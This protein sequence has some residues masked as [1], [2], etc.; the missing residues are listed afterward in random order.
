[1]IGIIL[2]LIAS[3]FFTASEMAFISCDWI[4]LRHWA[5]KNKKGAKFALNLLRNQDKLLITILVGNN[6]A[7]VGLSVI[8]SSVWGLQEG[9][10]ILL[11]ALLIFIFGEVLPKSIASRFKE[12]L[13]IILAKPYVVI[14]WLFYPLIFIVYHSSIGI[15]KLFNAHPKFTFHK[16]TR[17][18][19]RVASKKALSLPEHR[20]ISR[21]LDF[22]GKQ[23]KE[24]MIPK[25]RILSAPADVSLQE[26]KQIIKESGYSRVPVYGSKSPD[27]D[28]I[29]GVVEAKSLLIATSVSDAIKPCKFIDDNL[30]IEALFEELKNKE[31]FFALVKDRRGGLVGLITAEDV[32]E[33]LFGEIEDEYDRI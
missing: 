15:L 1:M 22:R 24:I 32:I 5:S 14:Y 10:V 28:E 11:T 31:N 16:F 33:E 8:A 26:L 29:I 6:L 3:A 2:L 18:D 30:S 12:Q 7:I 27:A 9:V 17:E 21:L 19:L 25:N 23:A 20:I 13:V 4:K